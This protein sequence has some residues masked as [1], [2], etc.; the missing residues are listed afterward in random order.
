MRLEKLR[1]VLSKADSFPYIIFDRNNIKYLTGFNGSNAFLVIDEDKNYFITDSRYELYVKSILDEKWDFFLQKETLYNTLV[2]IFGISY[3]KT[4]FLE[5]HKLTLQV[6]ND[7]KSTF[8]DAALIQSASFVNDLREIKD[9]NEINTIKKA[10][11]ISDNCFTHLLDYIKPGIT[12]WDIAVEIDYYYK[13]HGCRRNSFDSIVASGAGSAMPHY[14]PSVNKIIEDD[15]MLMIDMGCV[16][17]DYCS[18]MTRTIFLGS[19]PEGFNEIYNTVLNAQQNACKAVKAG[20]TASYLDSVARDIIKEAGYGDKFGHSLGHG[21][22][23]DVHENPFVK[24]NS[25]R[26]IQENALITV[27]PG[28]YIER[29]G[30]VRIED[31][32]LVKKD[33]YEILTESVKELIII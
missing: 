8:T 27:E 24:M 4:L 2:E 22:G 17:N 19:V 5:P 11:N 21:V 15:N 30:G 28:I 7:L 13:K 3:N 14:E 18:D 26:I 10:V 9:D 33:G 31:I 25:D 29:K 23:L 12:E 1:E 32:V 20:V 16:Y 6:F